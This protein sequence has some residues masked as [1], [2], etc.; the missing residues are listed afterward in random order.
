MFFLLAVFMLNACQDT[1]QEE[2]TVNVPAKGKLFIIG[3]GKRPTEMVKDMIHLSGVDTA[4]YIAVLPMASSVPDTSAYYAMKQFEDL[5]V[6]E[7]FNFNFQDSIDFSSSKV[8]SLE[9]ASLIYISG[10]DQNLFMEKV[11]S[12]AV[13]DAIHKAYKQ[14]AF[15]AGT[16][17]G[18]AVMS[19]R[20]ITGDEKKYPV[21]TG[22]FKTIEANNIEIAEGLGLIKNVIIDQHFIQRMRMNRLIST[23][24]ENPDAIGIGIDESTAILVDGPNA[25]VYGTG[26]VIKLV[27]SKGETRIE[28]GLLG[29]K[30]MN[31]SVFLPGDSFTIY[32]F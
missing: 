1:S 10:G 9:N 4:G 26:Q 16:S 31:L 19:K 23:C 25:K 24:L 15:I 27:H 28:G 3:G 13:F 5:G 18:A 21:Y 17:A 32:S 2:L 20:M 6:A 22:E 11:K 14:G 7:V 29:A 8:D 30:D 12:T